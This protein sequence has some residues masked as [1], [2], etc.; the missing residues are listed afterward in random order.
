MIWFI[1]IVVVIIIVRT[2]SA[3]RAG[4]E[5]KHTR[6]EAGDPDN[7]TYEELQEELFDEF[8]DDDR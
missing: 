6:G 4:V 1:V 5:Q 7:P 8:E 3:S 2:I